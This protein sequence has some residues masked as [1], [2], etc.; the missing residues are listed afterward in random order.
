M[1]RSIAVIPLHLDASFSKPQII[2]KC[3]GF[4]ISTKFVRT[5]VP[6]FQITIMD[7]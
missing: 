4:R 1:K 2:N 7:L 5:G 3:N 6:L